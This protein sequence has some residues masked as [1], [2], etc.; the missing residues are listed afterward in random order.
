MPRSH[1]FELEAFWM[2]FIIFQL[3]YRLTA[4]K[5]QHPKGES[6]LLHCTKRTFPQ[7]EL[8]D[9]FKLI[10]P[11]SVFWY[12][13]TQTQF[14]KSKPVQYKQTALLTNLLATT[15]PCRPAPVAEPSRHSKNQK[16]ILWRWCIP[17]TG[18]HWETYLVDGIDF[19]NQHVLNSGV[20]K[21]KDDH[22]TACLKFNMKT[23][24]HV[25]TPR[26]KQRKVTTQN[27]NV[28]KNPK[29]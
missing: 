1:L 5:H 25:P 23:M 26:S 3:N 11:A 28:W 20:Q 29:K 2:K 16:N 12:L 18:D 27:S 7:K 13:I 6:L 14:P 22:V 19:W 9:W 8:Q 10:N 4:W 17:S 15:S 24:E 21:S